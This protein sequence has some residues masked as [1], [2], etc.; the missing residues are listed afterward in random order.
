M[1]GFQ[2][3]KHKKQIKAVNDSGLPIIY[4]HKGYC[5]YLRL[6][7]LQAKK[8]NPDTRLILLGDGPNKRLAQEVGVAFYP[9]EN[10]FS[11]AT[12][13]ETIYR[14]NSANGYHYELFCFQRWFVLNEFLA[15]EK[16][17]G[18]FFYNDSD[19]FLFCDAA[20]V[21]KEFT[22]HYDLS[23]CGTIAPCFVFFKSADALRELC[24]FI[25]YQYADPEAYDFLV[26]NFKKRQNQPIGDLH[27][28][29]ETVSDMTMFGLFYK[30]NANRIINLSDYAVV[31][32]GVFEE[33]HY[34][35]FQQE[36]R[37]R[38]PF[39]RQ[40]KWRDGKPHYL[41]PAN[42]LVPVLGFHFQGH[43]KREMIKIFRGSRKAVPK[44]EYWKHQKN[45]Y[46]FLLSGFKRRLTGQTIHTA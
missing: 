17:T 46:R 18:H 38:F 6:S 44:S 43:A 2:T 9:F 5:P 33:N 45:L 42:E 26:E 37:S 41:T 7:L 8:T 22:Q 21:V 13:F 34:F 16:I 28:M 27:A 14:H 39:G 3:T 20:A 23:I 12:N 11:A 32:K 4:I 25:T 15:K 35:G 40:I 36:Y 10:Y 29:F 1:E 31:K 30:K 24:S 19:T